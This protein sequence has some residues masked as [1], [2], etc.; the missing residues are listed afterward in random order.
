MLLL[1][2]LKIDIWGC[3]PFTWERKDGTIGV[4]VSGDAASE[5]AMGD[6]YEPALC[7]CAS[8]G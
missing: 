5:I 8:S 6:H 4:S 1:E 2:Y 3:R 7:A